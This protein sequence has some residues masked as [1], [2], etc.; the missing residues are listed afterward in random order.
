MTKTSFSSI[1]LV[2]SPIQSSMWLLSEKTVPFWKV[3]RFKDQKHL[4]S[5][6][7]KVTAFWKGA[8][9]TS[10]CCFC[11]QPPRAFLVKN[12]GTFQKG[13]GDVTIILFQSLTLHWERLKW[14]NVQSIKR[15]YV[16]RAALCYSFRHKT[17]NSIPLRCIGVEEV[18]KP[19]ET[20]RIS[21]WQDTARGKRTDRCHPFTST[22]NWRTWKWV[23]FWWME[24]ILLLR[25]KSRIYIHSITH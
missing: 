15:W 1:F 20:K 12:L 22:L 17:C 14:K 16:Y 13:T 9:G 6:H 10:H 18:I 19:N 3:Q 7:K 4:G 2:T 24:T 8:L 11:G 23:S 21:A 5:L 25:L